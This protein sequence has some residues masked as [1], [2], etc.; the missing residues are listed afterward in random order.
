MKTTFTETCKDV[1][2]L[3]RLSSC[4]PILFFQAVHK[5][6][7]SI[8]PSNVMAPPIITYQKDNPGALCFFDLPFEM[9]Q[10][11][12]EHYFYCPTGFTIHLLD[13]PSRN[14]SS[15]FIRIPG[16]VVSSV[17]NDELPLSF[18]RLDDP[19]L[20]AKSDDTSAVEPGC[21]W[22]LLL[23]NRGI[24]AETLPHLD[25]INRFTVYGPLRTD[26]DCYH[27]HYQLEV[28]PRSVQN[29]IKHLKLDHN[30]LLDIGQTFRASWMDEANAHRKKRW[31]VDT[32]IEHQSWQT[33]VYS[34]T[35][36]QTLTVTGITGSDL[37]VF[38]HAW[39]MPKTIKLNANVDFE[40][41]IDSGCGEKEELKMRGFPDNDSPQWNKLNL[42]RLII[43]PLKRL[44][45][46][47][48]MSKKALETLEDEDFGG[49][50]LT[51][52]RDEPGSQRGV[53]RLVNPVQAIAALHQARN[54][55]S[56]DLT[57][58]A[59]V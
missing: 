18:F 3:L 46:E 24:L 15:I 40:M 16:V 10:K 47:C 8:A 43:P 52:V 59:S 5:Y 37:Q 23:V 26:R 34:M 2:F 32:W 39:K 19:R 22:P 53:Y 27:R 45:F 6:H 14:S 21:Y 50:E 9:R 25:A 13:R 33:I 51:R 11:V 7:T 49:S 35:N 48:R 54:Q 36:L 4:T 20:Q 44:S 29:N 41:I 57:R 12:Y 31:G 56:A 30:K 58:N 1:L 55:A 17:Y 28:V 42:P 38:L